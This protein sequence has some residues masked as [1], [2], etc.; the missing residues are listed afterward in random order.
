MERQLEA[1]AVVGDFEP[2][3]CPVSGE[4]ISGRAA[5]NENLAKQG[6]RVL[7]PGE[8]EDYKRQTQAADDAVA[9]SVAETAAKI[10]E[11]F[12]PEKKALLGQAL[13]APST[14]STYERN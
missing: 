1:P 4:W 10:V 7:E 3:A 8:T 11:G 12:S 2:Y 5:H 6:C 14:H 9:N 13:E